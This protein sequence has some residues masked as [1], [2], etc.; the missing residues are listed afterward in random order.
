MT[1]NGVVRRSKIAF[2]LPPLREQGRQGSLQREWYK[3]PAA[4]PGL[5]WLFFCGVFFLGWSS[6]PFPQLSC[7]ST[8]LSTLLSVFFYSLWISNYI[9]WFDTSSAVQDFLEKSSYFKLSYSLVQRER[10]ALQ[11]RRN[12]LKREEFVILIVNVKVWLYLKINIYRK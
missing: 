1:L 11:S 4:A 6:F 12:T 7:M 10:A 2:S 3:V 8:A 5:C 9:H